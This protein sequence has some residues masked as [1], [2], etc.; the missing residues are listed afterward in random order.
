MAWLSARQL[1]I[2][3]DTVAM[4]N[5]KQHLLQLVDRLDGPSNSVFCGALL[6]GRVFIDKHWTPS[7]QIHR[8]LNI[9]HLVIC[10]ENV[11]LDTVICQDIAGKTERS[12]L[13]SNLVGLLVWLGS[14]RNVFECHKLIETA[15]DMRGVSQFRV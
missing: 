2:R 3:I 6:L 14:E 4:V 12:A 8:G 1:L 7:K 13:H 15:S 11:L 5:P 9:V 10:E